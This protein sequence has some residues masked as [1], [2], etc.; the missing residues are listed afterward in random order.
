MS[1]LE[2]KIDALARQKAGKGEEWSPYRFESLED[3]VLVTGANHTLVTRGPTKGQRRWRGNVGQARVF[4]SSAEW[5]DCVD[6][7]KQS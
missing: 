1:A 7:A 5:A 2:E 6:Q 3:G 4:F